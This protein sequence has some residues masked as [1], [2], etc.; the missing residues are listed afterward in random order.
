MTIS[1]L[2]AVVALQEI[3]PAAVALEDFALGQVLL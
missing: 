1:W 3:E 2:L